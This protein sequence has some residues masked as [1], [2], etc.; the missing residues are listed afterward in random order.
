MKWLD[1]INK[2]GITCSLIQSTSNRLRQLP[3][4]ELGQLYY[5]VQPKS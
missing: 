2:V 3:L 1:Y 5:E 4:G